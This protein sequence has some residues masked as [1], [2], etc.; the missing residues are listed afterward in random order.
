M[1]SFIHQV[2]LITLTFLL[3]CSSLFIQA[4]QEVDFYI[5]A[6]QSNMM[7]SGRTKQ[8]GKEY[9][10]PLKDVYIWNNKA[11]KFDAFVA[12]RKFGPELGFAHRLRA[13]QPKGEIYMLKLGLSGQPL[14]HGVHDQKWVNNDFAPKRKNFYPGKTKDD[15]NQG[16]HYINLMQRYQSALTSLTKEKKKLVLKGV[17]W[18]QGEAD[19]KFEKS[20]DAYGASLTQFKKRLEEDTASGV[21]PFVFGKVLPKEPAPE[22]FIKRKEVHAQMEALDMNSNHKS[23]VLGMHLIEAPKDQMKKDSVHYTSEGYITLGVRFADAMIA[24]QKALSTKTK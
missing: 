17:V 8:V 14:H 15:P 1:K 21:V 13:L 2:R 9:T 19:C 18:M 4:E 3:G 12:P 6:G 7:G 11:K 22:K 5:L 20:G 23:S 10:K 24:V 16:V